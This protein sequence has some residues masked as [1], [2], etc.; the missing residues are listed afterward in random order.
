MNFPNKISQH[1]NQISVNKLNCN[2]F[3]F[4]II[5]SFFSLPLPFNFIATI[6]SGYSSLSLKREREKRV[7]LT[8]KKHHSRASS[9]FWQRKFQFRL[10]DLSK[11]PGG[12][13]R[14][15]M[16][17]TSPGGDRRREAVR[18]RSREKSEEGTSG[19]SSE[20]TRNWPSRDVVR[21]TWRFTK[22]SSRLAPQ[23]ALETWSKGAFII[24][25]ASRFR[26]RTRVQILL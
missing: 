17:S 25:Y 11:T 5:E 20:L 22:H 2:F 4:S 16:H 18:Y 19:P 21:P 26:R 23:R 1:W 6:I 8:E 12:L 7:Q 9:I 24:C 10:E 15:K 3:H 14:Y 13:V